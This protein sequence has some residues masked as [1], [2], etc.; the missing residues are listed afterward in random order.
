MKVRGHGIGKTPTGAYFFR[1]IRS[2][3]TIFFLTPV[4]GVMFPKLGDLVK[5]NVTT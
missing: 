5:E 2:I 1:K 4:G 3:A